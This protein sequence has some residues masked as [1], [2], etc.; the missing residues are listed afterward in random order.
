MAVNNI[1]IQIMVQAQQAQQTVNQFNQTL[2]Q[3]GP[4]AQKAGQQGAQGISSVTVALNETS[5][6]VSQFTSALAGLAVI[7][8]GRS[9][10]EAGD[11]ISRVQIGF[12]AMTGSAAMAVEVMGELR[13]IAAE[14]PFAFKDIAEGARRLQAFGFATREIPSDIEA[15][16]KAVKTIGGGTEEIDSITH[17]LGIMREKGVAQAQQL[18]RTLAAQ[19][20]DVMSFIRKR[21]EEDYGQILDDRQIRNLIQKGRLGGEQTAEAILEGIKK[22]PDSSK[23]MM[24]LMS[25]HLQKVRDEFGF[26]AKKVNEDVRPTINKALDDITSTMRY[27]E[28]HGA[29]RKAGEWFTTIVS[30]FTA[31]AVA[32]RAFEGLK[33]AERFATITEAIAPFTTAVGGLSGALMILAGAITAVGSA[34][35]L[36]ELLNPQAQQEARDNLKKTGD[37]VKRVSKE[38]EDGLKR[39]AV[40]AYEHYVPEQQ[41]QQVQGLR[42]ALTPIPAPPMPAGPAAPTSAELEA[43]QKAR[44]ARKKI[45]EEAEE[46]MRSQ[47]EAADAILA[48]AQEAATRGLPAIETRF[49]HTVKEM[50]DAAAL[51]VTSVAPETLAKLAKAETIEIDTFITEQARKG[52]ELRLTEDK[53][54]WEDQLE[55]AKYATQVEADLALSTVQDTAEKQAQAELNRL[56]AIKRGADLELVYRRK[57]A[58]DNYAIAKGK[59]QDLINDE[60]K[61]TTANATQRVRIN[62]VALGLQQKDHDDYLRELEKAE[63]DSAHIVAQARAE[64][65]RQAAQQTTEYLKSIRQ[66][67]DQAEI[68]S[69]QRQIEIGRLQF[70]NGEAQTARQKIAAIDQA[71]QYELAAVDHVAQI[72]ARQAYETALD[73]YNSKIALQTQFNRDALTLSEQGHDEEA[74]DAWNAANAQ[75]ELAMAIQKKFYTEDVIAAQEAAD[76]KTVLILRAQK[77]ANDAWIAEQRQVFEKFESGVGRVFDALFER[78]KSFWA[79]MGDLAL[80]TGKQMA[81]ALIVPAVSASLMTAMG[82]PVHMESRGDFGSGAIAQFAQLFTQHPVFQNL[83]KNRLEGALTPNGDAI[84]VVPITPP[85]P[86]HPPNFQF[87]RQDFSFNLPNPPPI[88]P[89][90]AATGDQPWVTSRMGDIGEFDAT[91]MPGFSGSSLAGYGAPGTGSGGS[92]GLGALLS[93]FSGGPGGGS[94]GSSLGSV[95]G[96]GGG[97]SL[98]KLVGMLN[99]PA[100]GGSGGFSLFKQGSLGSSLMNLFKGGGGSLYQAAGGLSSTYGYMPSEIT[101]AADLPLSFGNPAVMLPTNPGTSALASALGPVALM[102]GLMGMKGAFSL[103]QFFQNR[104]SSAAGG[105]LGGTLGAFSGLLTAGGLAA[106]FPSIFVPLLAAGP[107]GWIAAAGIGAAIGLMGAF[108]TTDQQHAR[109]LI[110]QMYGV[111]ISNLSILN[112]VVAIAKQ[113]YGGMISLAVASPDVQQLVNLYAAATGQ[114]YG[115]PRPMYPALY[116]QSAGGL[117]LQPTYSNGQLVQSPY[118]GTTTTQWTMASQ[119]MNNPQTAMYVQLDPAMASALFQGQVINVLN[120]NP[121]VVGN[122]AASSINAGSTRNAQ[123]GGL[124]EPLTVQS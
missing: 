49:A 53:K 99:S 27:F 57:I 25:S 67:E 43:S 65:T 94:F 113:K 116:S 61:S 86:I 71:T 74:K 77:E 9:M 26:L 33:I 36:W 39:G 110:K 93:A 73:E 56:D 5:R 1:T 90:P 75:Y 20:I 42:R 44:A 19:G 88:P 23:E 30:G 47:A 40:S 85:A 3:M 83:P 51:A 98:P 102:G 28:E 62:A 55:H 105:I 87:N 48:R 24:D 16:A 69:A 103:G 14:S 115:G 121:T 34:W 108:K 81:K 82:M 107:I 89:P 119:L 100:G 104:G 120:Q 37:A 60:F 2:A 64:I 29:A 91:A 63:V 117:Q 18:F 32:W 95:P 31:I 12:K 84:R 66:D 41:Q 54:Y 76:E 112:Q 21:I 78:G 52:R 123:L 118:T 101:S 17:A 68:A 106:A 7:Q 11:A 38:I 111:D 92:S 59:T 97:F 124:L 109:Q 80:E 70:E 45:L 46:L 122:A 22:I 72:R 58:E 50:K 35:G 79:R 13:G 8:L 114:R 4:A 10:M 15:I 96:A 6:A